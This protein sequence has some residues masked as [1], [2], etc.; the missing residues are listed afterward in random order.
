MRT[1]GKWGIGLA[2]AQGPLPAVFA[3]FGCEVPG[4]DLAAEDGRAA[5]WAKTGRHAANLATR[6]HPNRRHVPKGQLQTTAPKTE[7]GN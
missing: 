6:M 3:S 1:E 4:T 2:V 7:T 5:D